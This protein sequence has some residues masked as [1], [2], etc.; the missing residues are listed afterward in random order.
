VHFFQGVR[1]NV[2][3]PDSEEGGL[4]SVIPLCMGVM[5]SVKAYYARDVVFCA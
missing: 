1:R 2:P 5:L 4:A 3:G